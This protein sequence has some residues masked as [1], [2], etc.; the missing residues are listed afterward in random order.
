MDTT[1]LYLATGEVTKALHYIQTKA[2]R[3]PGGRMDVRTTNDYVDVLE[4][5]EYTKDEIQKIS[6]WTY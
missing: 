4:R 6:S 5:A 3:T 2:F 1:S